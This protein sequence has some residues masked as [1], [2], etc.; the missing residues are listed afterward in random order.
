M[1]VLFLISGGESSWWFFTNPFE[2]TKPVNL[3][4]F[5]RVRGENQ[6]KIETTTYS[7]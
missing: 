7:E 3:D 6:Q 5:P 2:K 4:H 1:T